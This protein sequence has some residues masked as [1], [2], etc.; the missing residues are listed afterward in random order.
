[1]IKGGHTMKLAE[2]LIQRSDCKKRLE[3]LSDRLIKCAK[4]QEGDN[5]PESP[6]ELLEEIEHVTKELENLI[7]LINRTNSTVKYDDNFTLSEALTK[8]DTIWTKRS[9][10]KNLI[11]NARITQNRYSKSEVRFQSTV[12]ISQIQNE[13]DRLAKEFRVIDT[14]VQGINWTTNL[15]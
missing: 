14:K 8:R 4:V 2:A 12:N 13:V 9:I 7:I 11:E 10:L 6:K 3:Q 1:M 5:P 15:V